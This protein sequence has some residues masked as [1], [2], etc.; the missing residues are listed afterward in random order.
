MRMNQCF[1]SGLMILGAL[2]F[3]KA[4]LASE[5]SSSATMFLDHALMVS[6]EL[7]KGNPDE[8]TIVN[9]VTSMLTEAVPVIKA[10]IVL[11]PQCSDQL[12][13]V[14]NLYPSIEQWSAQE[15]RLNIEAAQALPAGENCYPARDIVAHP[16]I[17]R[18]LSRT[19]LTSATAKRL[20]YE[21]EEAIEHMKEIADTLPSDL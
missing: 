2:T 16:A 3:S 4:T 20:T 8:T 10:Y 11:Q 1:S 18:A 15:I 13:K 21:I 6:E 9:L 14:I 19:E 7:H 17:V 12:L 5:A